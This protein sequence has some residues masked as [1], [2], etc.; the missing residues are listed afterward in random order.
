[1][2]KFF[3]VSIL[4]LTAIMISIAGYSS[5]DK[6][7]Q[8]SCYIYVYR[9]GQFSGAGA[10]WA[11]FLDDQKICKLSNNKYMRLAVTP[12]MHRISA[13]VGGVGVLKKETEVEIDAQKGQSHYIACNVKS[14]VIRVRLEMIEVTKSSANKQMEKMTLD[15]CQ[16]EI[17]E[18]QGQ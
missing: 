2:K 12:G 13:K 1:M 7:N 18:K 16:E 4:L 3:F 15:N 5:G 6:A 11:V 10:N 8:D 17:D 9:V 14:S